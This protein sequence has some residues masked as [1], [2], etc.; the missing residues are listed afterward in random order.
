MSGTIIPGS[1]TIAVNDRGDDDHVRSSECTVASVARDIGPWRVT[2]QHKTTAL[3]PNGARQT[4][5]LCP[6]RHD[7]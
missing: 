5:A 7:S 3:R 2:S 1:G 6:Q 4:S